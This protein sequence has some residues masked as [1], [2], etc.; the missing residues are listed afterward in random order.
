MGFFIFELVTTVLCAM[1]FGLYFATT[2][3]SAYT[4]WML[5]ALVIDFTCVCLLYRMID[6]KLF[7]KMAN[8]P[9]VP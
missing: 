2:G 6:R 5:V 3:F 8:S 9:R 7:E 1:L 4:I